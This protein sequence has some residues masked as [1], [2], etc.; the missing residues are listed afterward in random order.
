MDDLDFTVP[1][2]ETIYDPAVAL[3]CFETLGKPCSLAEGEAFFAEKEKSDYMYLLLEGEVRL[4][5][6]VRVLDIVRSG[7]IFGEMA[8]I[9]GQPRSAWAVARKPC[10]ALMLDPIQFQEAIWATPEFALMLMRIMFDRLRLTSEFLNKSG[11]L[12]NSGKTHEKVFS[13]ALVKQLA[14][15]MGAHEPEKIPAT[16]TIMREGES[17][18]TMYVVLS[19]EIAVSIQGTFVERIGVG[20]ILG[21]IALVNNSPRAASAV[22]LTEVR[23]LPIT[24]DNFMNLVKSHPAFV[25]SLLRAIATRLEIQ[26]AKSALMDR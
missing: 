26:T 4:F 8:V 14:S 17:D 23:L 21:E 18:S 25:V 6:G 11:R 3:A 20:G 7:E 24:R 2:H 16:T 15:A 12:R 10:S 13:Q 1:T 22:A 5:R 9:T 19:G